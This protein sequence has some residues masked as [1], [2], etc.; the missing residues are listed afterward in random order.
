MRPLRSVVCA[1]DMA[2]DMELGSGELFG[3]A[4]LRRYVLG[5][6]RGGLGGGRAGWRFGGLA[7]RREGVACEEAGC[8]ED[9][10]RMVVVV[11]VVV[12]VEA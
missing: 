11:V 7:E 1:L 12:Y 9:E 8:A 5:I 6:A 4:Q 3:L 10:G 2:L